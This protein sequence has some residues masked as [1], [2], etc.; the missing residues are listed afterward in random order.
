MDRKK[1]T[2]NWFESEEISPEHIGLEVRQIYVWV[3]SNDSRVAI[4][5]KNNGD[6]QFPGGHPEEGEDSPETAVRE[7]NE[8]VGLDISSYISNLRFFGYYLIEENNEKYLQLRYLLQLPMTSERYTL[9]MNERS[10]EER[11]VAS[12]QWVELTKLPNYIT[13]TKGLEEYDRVMDLVLN[14]Y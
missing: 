6:S 3:V 8:E 10:D 4:V 7:V 9:S 12:A 13:W 1:I 11:P 5:T 2:R 14:K